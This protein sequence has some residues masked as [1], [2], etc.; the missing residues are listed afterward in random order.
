M[1]KHLELEGSELDFLLHLVVDIRLCE[2]GR[3]ESAR[4]GLPEKKKRESTPWRRY[5]PN[6]ARSIPT[7]IGS[8]DAE[9]GSPSA[10][11]S[12]TG[13]YTATSRYPTSST[14]PSYIRPVSPAQKEHHGQPSHTPQRRKKQYEW[15]GPIFMIGVLSCVI[16]SG[17]L[18]S[19]PRS[20]F[21]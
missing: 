9:T 14:F 6:P 16:Q 10:P 3:R 7:V 15:S 5:V 8:V 4:R 1:K 19:R 12:L 2:E 11:S 21:G 20:V 17:Q 18:S 13:V